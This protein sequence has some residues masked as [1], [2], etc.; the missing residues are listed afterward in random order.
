MWVFER[1]TDSGQS[2]VLSFLSPEEV[3][4]MGG[5]PAEA[6][7][8]TVSIGE[9]EA[10]DFR[11]NPLFATFM[12]SVLAEYGPDDSGLRA[13]AAS[14]GEGWIYIIDLRTPDG[15][16]GRVPPVD[17][18]GGFEVRA[19]VIIAGS[20]QPMEAHRIYTENGL[21]LLPPSLRQALVD[22]WAT[23]PGPDVPI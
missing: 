8:G 19:G 6:I 13:A 15:P 3:R 11:E 7:A 9:G 22:R 14:Q 12:H 20:Y 10:T 1:D 23:E 2:G 4:S 5:L 17:I 18:V 16:Q 21:V